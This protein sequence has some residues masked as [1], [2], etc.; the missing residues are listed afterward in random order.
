MVNLAFLSFSFGAGMVSFFSPCAAALL[1]AYIVHF[2]RNH[3]G[4]HGVA[5]PK[6]IWKGISFS[7][8]GILG[9]LTI[10][11]GFGLL[12]LLFG[13]VIKPF[14]PRIAV[15]TGVILVILGVL[16]LF[17]KD[18]LSLNLPHIK[19]EKTGAYLFGIAYAVA[20][21]G[22]TFPIFL[23]VVF[24]GFT[25]PNLLLGT[26]PLLAYI[27][28]ISSLF[29]AVTTLVIFSREWISRKIKIVTPYIIKIEGIILIG[30]GIYM[31]W[32]QA[33]LL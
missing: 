23:A 10:F 9:F 22:C 25:Q 3:G 5:W 6:K 7:F 28:G 20:A 11:G 26:F 30:A 29:L 4:D 2:M 18:F 21:L 16:V 33:V 12:L 17:K 32:Y 1:P 19:Q 24:Q 15:V 8:F 27:L 31:V 13:Q 14:I